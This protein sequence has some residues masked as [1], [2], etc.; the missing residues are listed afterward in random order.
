[1][2]K[3]DV[4]ISS[5]SEDYKY[6]R[7]IYSFLVGNGAN[8][9]FADEELKNIGSSE[10]SEA[11]DRAIED[12]THMIVFASELEFLNSTWVKYEWRTFADEIK[13][14]RKKGNI[15]T[16]LKNV[17]IDF[18]PIA[19]RNHQSFE[20]TSYQDTLLNYV[21]N[22]NFNNKTDT[23]KCPYRKKRSYRCYTL[24]SLSSLILSF[25]FSFFIIQTNIIVI[26]D[27]AKLKY[28]ETEK[29]KQEERIETQIKEINRRIHYFAGRMDSAY[30]VARR[31]SKSLAG[32]QFKEIMEMDGTL[33][34]DDSKENFNVAIYPLEIDQSL[35]DYV[36]CAKIYNNG[37]E[38]VDSLL[39]IRDS[40]KKQVIN[41]HFSNMDLIKA[42]LKIVICDISLLIR[43]LAI[44]LVFF[45]LSLFVINKII[46]LYE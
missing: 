5:K 40:I 36:E 38:V 18:V 22:D 34:Y 20:Y 2:K 16:I 26:D 29:L 13:S 30:F 42:K 14:G 23:A 17:Q 31:C 41:M 15:V 4:F 11:I 21:T 1:M 37:F 32:T 25:V 46:R 12:S 8:V 35:I 7:D 28:I 10:Y 33:E 24:I 3:Y 6:A 19:L 27:S 45:I 9:F 43:Y 39:D 44:I